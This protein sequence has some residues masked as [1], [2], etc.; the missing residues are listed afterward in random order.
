M[1]WLWLAVIG[2]NDGMGW[3][4]RQA[5]NGGQMAPKNPRKKGQKPKENWGTVFSKTFDDCLP[6]IK[7]CVLKR[8]ANQ[9]SLK[10]K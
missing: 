9:I 1:A 10:I 4:S 6:E 3:G 5:I 2:A 7:L 8:M